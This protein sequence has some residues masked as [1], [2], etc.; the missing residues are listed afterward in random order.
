MNNDISQISCVCK[1]LYCCNNSLPPENKEHQILQD[2]KEVIVSEI[3]S[4]KLVQFSAELCRSGVISQEVN[5]VFTALD[6]T[7]DAKLRVRY[8][9]LQVCG[10][11]KHNV[12][13][14]HRFLKVLAGYGGLAGEVAKCLG[15]EWCVSEKGEE[16]QVVGDGSGSCQA[17]GDDLLGED[18]AYLMK[19]LTGVTYIW[20]ELGIALGLPKAVL[21]ECRNAGNNSLRLHNLLCI[22]VKGKHQTA[23][24]ATLKNLKQELAS[25]LVGVADVALGLE[26]KFEEAKKHVSILG[27]GRSPCLATSLSI[28]Y[29]SNNMEVADSKSTLLEVQ[30]GEN[31]TPSYQWMKDGQS[32]SDNLVYYGTHTAIL[33]ITLASQLIQGKYTCHVMKCNEE[34]V[35][36]EVLLT[37][38]FSPEKKQLI[39]SYSKDTDVPEDTW[40]PKVTSTF[41][42]LALITKK[43]EVTDDYKYSVRGDVDDILETKEKVEF[44]AVFGEFQSGALVLV[45]GRPGSGK[46]TLVHKV[47]RD[48]ATGG[49]VLKN[50]KLVFLILLRGL[51]NTKTEKLSDILDLIYLDKEECE[52]VVSDI[53]QSKG[54]GVCFIIDGLD[55]FHPQD[56][57]KSVIHQLLY[58]KYLS[59]AMVIVASRPVATDRLRRKPHVTRRIEVLGFSQQHVFEYIDNF[60]FTSD[61]PTN[62]DTLPSQLKVYLNSH[63]NLLHMCYLPVHV[64]MIYFLYDHEKVDIPPTETEIYEHFTRF[65]VLRKQRRTNEEAYLS[66]LEDLRGED[67]EYF[68]SICHLAFDMTIRSTQTVYQRDT[69]IPLSLGTGPDDAPSLGL[70]TIDRTAGIHGLDNTYAFLHLTFQEYLAAFHLAKLKEKEQIEMIR[71]CAGEKHMRMVWKFYCGIGKFENKVAQI[72]LIIRSTS[73]RPEDANLYGIQCAYESQQRVVCDSIVK[74]STG[75]LI[76]KNC[77]LTLA[78]MTALGYVIST[79]SHPVTEQVMAGCHLHDDHVRTLL[80][81][82]SHIKLKCMEKLDLSANKICADGAAAL[83]Y[84]LKSSKNLQELW[85][86]DNNIGADGAA[87]LADGFKSCNNLKTFSLSDNNIGD[88]GAAALADGLKYCNNLQTLWLSNNSISADGAAALADGLK[89]SNNL[90]TLWLSFNNIGA[91]GV[92]ALRAHLKCYISY[93][94]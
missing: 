53:K 83:A 94:I 79:T 35:S 12:A 30:V 88:S 50:A 93:K 38:N 64:A 52:K 47:T 29:Q 77:T 61:T 13:I 49:G 75:N 59:A 2:N 80:R 36:R 62:G 10:G 22:W 23:K 86:F 1:A 69:K 72:M 85:L 70:V 20:E 27:V 40:P 84:G 25:E 81:E 55:E 41:I 56:E 28:V 89:S 66:S 51:A 16:G 21:E 4:I 18:V 33:A 87:T 9:L 34:V 54:E 17:L 46:T 44:A 71:L 90:R 6:N 7:V 26:A 11:V 45:E 58:T 78:D 42:N 74:R 5:D 8:L 57:T 73:T 43:K 24:P 76:Y 48:W 14:F 68:S 15:K 82:V 91:D 67:R 32:L 3:S 92:T 60:P 39:N 63:H 31:Q 37:V 19:I 65:I